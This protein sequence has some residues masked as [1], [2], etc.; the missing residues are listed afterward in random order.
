MKPLLKLLASEM[1]H[2]SKGDDLYIIFTSGTLVSPKECGFPMKSPQLY[3][4]DD[5]G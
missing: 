5:Y 3:Q 1:T 4:L 2:Q